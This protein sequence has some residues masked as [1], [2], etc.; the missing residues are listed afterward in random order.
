[1]SRRGA[2]ST[3]AGSNPFRPSS[4]SQRS[5]LARRRLRQHEKS[6]AQKPGFG[7]GRCETVSAARCYESFRRDGVRGLFRIGRILRIAVVRVGE[8]R[9]QSVRRRFRLGIAAADRSIRRA[10]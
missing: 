8:E 7:V 6:P 9:G 10:Q 2:L 5:S 3:S 1:M 4:H